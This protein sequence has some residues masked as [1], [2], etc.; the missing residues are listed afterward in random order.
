VRP[1]LAPSIASPSQRQPE[2][3]RYHLQLLLLLLDPLSLLFHCGLERHQSQQT[4]SSRITDQGQAYRRL[5]YHWRRSLTTKP[6]T[7]EW[8]Q[9]RNQLVSSERYR[10]TAF[11]NEATILL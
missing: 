3:A 4:K 1:L 6:R 2:K 9:R 10:V 8:I 5:M 7:K 11:A